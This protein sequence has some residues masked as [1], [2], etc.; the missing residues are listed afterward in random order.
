MSKVVFVP[1]T[2]QITQVVA[3]N[4]SLTQEGNTKC[5]ISCSP[6]QTGEIHGL[7]QGRGW[8]Y[9]ETSGINAS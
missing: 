9:T 1:K 7:Y 5:T 2:S 8:F 6:Q 3:G 4:C